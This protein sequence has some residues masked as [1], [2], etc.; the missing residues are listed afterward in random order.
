MKRSRVRAAVA[1]EVRIST[2]KVA[3]GVALTMNGL[4]SSGASP[5]LRS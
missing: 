2:M 3:S 4:S 5:T 1:F